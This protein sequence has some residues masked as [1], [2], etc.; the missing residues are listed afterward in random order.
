MEIGVAPASSAPASATWNSRRLR[1]IS[2]TRSPGR[3]PADR[4]PPA[5]RAARSRESPQVQISPSI[6]RNAPAPP[7][8][9][10]CCTRPSATLRRSGNTATSCR[11]MRET[12]AG[13]R[14][15]ALMTTDS[16]AGHV[17]VLAARSGALPAGQQLLRAGAMLGVVT[18]DAA[19]IDAL[20][21]EAGG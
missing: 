13:R 12:Y 2:T 5:K 1:N 10:P 7:R 9:R 16:L 19:A 14:H 4:S 17:V 18:A 8:R 21:R 3:T 11:A 20:E 6:G 15:S